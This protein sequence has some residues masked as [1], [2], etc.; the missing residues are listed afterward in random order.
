M[1]EDIRYMSRKRRGGRA[2]EGRKEDWGGRKEWEE[3]SE[4][5]KSDLSTMVIDLDSIFPLL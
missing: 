1:C 2:K 5:M 4:R 3:K